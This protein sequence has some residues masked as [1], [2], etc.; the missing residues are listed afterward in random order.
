MSFAFNFGRVSASGSALQGRHDE[1]CRIVLMGDFSGRA[2]RGERRSAD[3]LAR[4]K[5]QRLG[6]AASQ[7]RGWEEAVNNERMPRRSVAGENP[8]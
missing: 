5:V 6:W 2:H 4:C 8:G 3:E 7:M 1:V